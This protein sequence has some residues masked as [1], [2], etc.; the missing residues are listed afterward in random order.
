MKRETI[1]KAHENCVLQTISTKPKT[2]SITKFTQQSNISS[3]KPTQFQKFTPK[4][5][6]FQICAKPRR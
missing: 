6:Q 2:L 3:R 1:N 4:K 5:T